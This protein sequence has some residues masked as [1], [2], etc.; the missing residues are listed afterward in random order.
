MSPSRRTGIAG[1]LVGFA[2]AGCQPTAPPPQPTTSLQPRS[3]A[4][5]LSTGPS[6]TPYDY[7]AFGISVD[8]PAGWRADADG[9]RALRW[10]APAGTAQLALDVPKLPFHIPGLLPIGQV[11]SGYVD[12]VKSKRL[13]D[14]SSTELTPPRLPDANVRRVVVAGH[15]KGGTA[16]REEAVLIVHGDAVYV[17][18]CT[19]DEADYPAAHAALDGAIA[20]VRWT[21]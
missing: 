16:R 10:V 1:L 12:D 20:S 17:L 15:D 2:A 7:P 13:T 8:L 3:K 11:E 6:V 4:T 5:P 19:A 18:S 21:K 9:D 14:G